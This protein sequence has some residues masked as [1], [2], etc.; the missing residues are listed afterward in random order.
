[1]LTLGYARMHLAGFCGDGVCANDNKGP[2]GYNRATLRIQEAVW[3]LMQK[4]GCPQVQR[5]IRTCMSN[6][7]FTAGRDIEKIVKARINGTYANVFDKWYE[8]LDA[9]P[10]LLDD[11]ANP[12]YQDV[13]DRG[14]VC[15]QYDP[16]RPMQLAVCS[17]LAETDT[18]YLLIQGWDETDREVRSN[19]PDGII[20]GEYV[21]ITKDVLFYTN[22]KFSKIKSVIKPRTNGY[23]MLAG[24]TFTSTGTVDDRHHLAWYHPDDERPEFRR[25]AFKALQDGTRTDKYYKLHAVAQMKF[26]PFWRDTDPI[27][28]DSIPLIKFMLQAM[29]YYDSG[30]PAKGRAYEQLAEQLMLEFAD[31]HDTVQAIPDVQM[32]GYSMGTNIHV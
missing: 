20:L 19:T 18:S 16:P 24:V 15:T 3:R 17:D 1:M 6:G 8:F 11:Q 30:D 25:Y 27:W 13:I 7:C 29:K 22:A 28:P 2:N 32:A 4:P 23:V 10:G 26:V 14:L 12:G 9:G 5:C 21:P 31:T